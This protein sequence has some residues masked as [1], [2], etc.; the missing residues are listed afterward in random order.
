[1]N[2]SHVLA[3]QSV[4]RKIFLGDSGFETTLQSLLSKRHS[5]HAEITPQVANIINDLKSGGDQTLFTLTEKW[6]QFRPKTLRLS[7][8]T[9]A[10]TSAECPQSVRDALSMAAARIR[11]YSNKQLPSDYLYTDATAT[12]LGWRWRPV[13]SAGLY[14]PGGLATYPS[15]VLMNAIPAKVAG[16]KRLVVTVPAKEGVLNPAVLA[17]CDIA[18]VDEIYTIGGAQAIA[19]LAYGTETIAPVD[20]IVGP[21]NAY[22]AEAKR[23]VYGQVGIDMIAGPSE[24]LIIS[25]KSVPAHWI[26]MDLL[27]QA[28]HDA[29][30]QSILITDDNAYADEVLHEVE[31]A[32]TNLPRT[33]I[34]RKSWEDFGAIIVV[35]NL[36]TD[37]PKITDQIAP[38]H[39]QITTAN[40]KTIA[41]HIQNAGA[42]FLGRMTPEAIGD[43]IAGPSHVLPTSGSARFASGLS[44]FDFLK[45]T[46]IIQCSEQ[47]FATLVPHAITL[48]NSEGLD[49][50]LRS[51]QLRQPS[52]DGA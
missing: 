27:S 21:G 32:L 33:A 19:A 30:A 24:V 38:E 8:D 47:S 46:S 23:Q 11:D 26:A 2:G 6:D 43:Y 42:I 41:E 10:Q 18:G 35:G 36:L 17:A 51:M 22:V 50:H 48:A 34:A 4:A 25:D 3:R 45:R 13:K 40:A 39:L 28:E 44:V 5:S 1:M 7:K 15:S 9:I 37:A 14:V 52:P 20:V 49:A 12:T 16:V 29:K 31:I